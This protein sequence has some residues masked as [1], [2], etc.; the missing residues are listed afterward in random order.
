MDEPKRLFLKLF[1][2]VILYR[3]QEEIL[4]TKVWK[5]TLDGLDSREIAII[6]V[7]VNYKE[8]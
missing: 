5:G 2:S 3:D 7:C 4:V 8:I 6:L 1:L